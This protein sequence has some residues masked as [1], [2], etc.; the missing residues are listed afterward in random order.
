VIALVQIKAE[1]TIYFLVAEPPGRVRLH[2]SYVLPLSKQE[3]IDHARYL[4]SLGQSVF[5]GSHGA[6]VVANVVAAKDDVNRNFQD[7]KFPNWSWQVSEFLGFAD[8]TIEILDGSPTQLEWFDW[9]HGG[10]ITI[11]FWNY[12]V[13]RELGP[14]PLYLLV[15]HS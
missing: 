14:V 6:L 10:Q 4:I 13:V 5:S 1:E 15:R 11:G 7:P 12:T 2:D 3:D 9:S 8:Y